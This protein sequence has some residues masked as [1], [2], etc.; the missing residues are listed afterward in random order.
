MKSLFL[1]NELKYTGKELAPHWIYK[2]FQVQ[3]DT[4]VGFIGECEVKLDNMVDIQDVIENSPIYSQKML[5]FIVE[6]FN[7]SLVEGVVRQRFLI[8]IAAEI[9][10]SYLPDGYKITRKGDDLF[11]QGG[12]LSV[13]IATKSITSVLI[14]IGINIF[15]EGAPIKASGLESELLLK[16]HKQIA[17][18]IIK[19]YCNECE[20]IIN[21]SCKVRGV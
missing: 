20:E 7:M 21:A 5:N 14:H 10:Q 13:S 19:Q 2:N 6:H 3:G 9:I 11:F 4:I 18:D 1:E 16:N 12:K 15:S 8:A 17:H